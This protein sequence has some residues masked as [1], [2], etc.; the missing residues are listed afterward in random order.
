MP[1]E[2][3]TPIPVIS[4]ED[5]YA[6]DEVML[7]HAFAIHG[8]FG[9]LLD[10]S[11]Y[12]FELENRCLKDGLN[13]KREVRIRIRHGP[14]VRDYFIDLL[15]N[16]STIVEAKAVRTLTQAH[17]G[18]GLN[19]LLLA[20]THHGS[21]V[22]FRSASVQRQFL[23]TRLTHANRT[24]FETD[25]FDWPDDDDHGRLRDAAVAFCADV[26][27]GLDVPLYREA[28]TS[29]LA[30]ETRHLVR[31]LSAR[32]RIGHH[33]MH[34]LKPGTALAVTAL[35]NMKHYRLHLS[36]LLAVTDLDGIAWLNMDL[37][38]ITLVRL[39]RQND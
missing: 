35:S 32:Q 13:V 10:E 39:N 14:F 26:G 22:N 12:K 7:R 18:Q 29:L 4:Q 28:L 27:L 2:L 36:R 38:R 23:S 1:I 33:E 5:F 9:R 30:I 17:H 3:S 16:E 24:H 8:K 37:G 19:Y 31:I 6:I 15:F 20:G 21:L 11:V 34:L 25:H